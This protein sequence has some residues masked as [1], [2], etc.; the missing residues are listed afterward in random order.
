VQALRGEVDEAVLAVVP[1]AVMYLRGEPATMQQAPANEGMVAEVSKF[2]AQRAAHLQSLGV[3]AE[4]AHRAR[5]RFRVRQDAA[6][7]SALHRG[8][9]QLPELGFPVL[10]GWSYKSTLGTIAGRPVHE[11]QVASVA[12]ALAAAQRGV[13]VL[14]VHHVAATVDALKKRQALAV[15]PAATASTNTTREGIR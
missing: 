15:D 8:M 10:V 6:Y 13:R 4:R 2:L 9:A 14:R 12:A 3:A 1:R 7:S 11:R 5:L